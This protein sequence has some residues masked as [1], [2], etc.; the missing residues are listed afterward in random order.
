MLVDGVEEGVVSS[1]K[2]SLLSSNRGVVVDEVYEETGEDEHG[3]V[4]VETGEGMAI[5]SSCGEVLY[6]E[7]ESEED[8]MGVVEYAIV[9]E[10]MVAVDVANEVSKGKQ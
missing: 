8:V 6:K 3:G 9:E 5:R 10:G 7:Y 1:W 4:S 2:K